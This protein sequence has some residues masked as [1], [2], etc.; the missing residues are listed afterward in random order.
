MIKAI[1]GDVRGQFKHI[2]WGWGE[3]RG[4]KNDQRKGASKKQREDSVF[5]SE[6]FS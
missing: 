3:E 6:P 2:T 5:H 1:T 4:Q